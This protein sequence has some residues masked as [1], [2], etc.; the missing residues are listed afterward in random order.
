MT[1]FIGRGRRAAAGG[2]GQEMAGAGA[3]GGEGKGRFATS[4]S[5]I[6]GRIQEPLSRWIRQRAGADYVDTVTEPGID[7]RLSED[8]AVAGALRKKAVISVKAH[9]SRMIVVSGH[10]DCAGNPVPDDAHMRQVAE[11]A[12]IVESWG[13]GAE[14]I[15]VFVDSGRRVVP[16]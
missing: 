12:R 14:V 3:N 4:L 1:A 15:G 10:A 5:C 13:T 9:G 11:C 7:K 2:E 16:V 8:A 6:D